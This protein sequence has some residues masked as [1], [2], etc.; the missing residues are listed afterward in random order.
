LLTALGARSSRA[1]REGMITPTA[2]P[3]VAVEARAV[4]RGR[5]RPAARLPILARILALA[6]ADPT[7]AARLLDHHRRP[8]ASRA[9]PVGTVPEAQAVGRAVTAA[10]LPVVRVQ[11]VVAAVVAGIPAVLTAPAGPAAAIRRGMR[12]TVA[13]AVVEPLGSRI[14]LA[15]LA[16][17]TAGVVVVAAMGRPAMVRRG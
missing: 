7:V 16:A 10:R 14:T 9:L 13:A 15:G 6:A 3:V 12:R 2:Q 17:I 1:V 4:Q 11:P 8:A 5:A